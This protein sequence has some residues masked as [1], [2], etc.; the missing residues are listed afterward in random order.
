MQ[1]MSLAE[2]TTKQ[3][4]AF[5]YSGRTIAFTLM[6]TML[7]TFIATLDQTVVGTALPRIV[8]DLQGFEQIAWIT[9]IFLLTSTVTIP[10]Y[11]KLSDLF[12]RKVIFLAAITIFLIGSALCGAAQSMTHLVIFRALQGTGAGGLQPIA[13]AVVADLFSPRQ[14]GRWVG[15]TSSSYALASIV[16]PLTGGL[17]TDAVSWRWVF[18]INLPLGLIAMGVLIFVMP[19]LRTPNKR[20]IID[21]VGTLLIVLA[22][23]PLLLGFTWAGDG[24]IDWLSWQSLGLFG[25][26][27]VLLVVLVVYSAWQERLG[28]GPIVEPSMFKNVRIFSVSLLTAMLISVVLIGAVYFLPVF[29]QSV[30]GVSATNSGLTLIPFALFSIAGAVIGGQITT[31]TGRYKLQALAASVLMIVGVLLLL[32]LDVHSN[33]L[34]V[35]LALAPLGI[36][37]GSSL[38]LFIVVIQNAMPQQKIGQATAAAIF[39]R[40]I[41]QSLG[42]A[43]IGS[44]VIGSYVPA[45]YNALPSGLKQALPAQI[46]KV[47][48]NP[49]VLLSQDAMVKIGAGFEHFGAQGHAA[50]QA[51]LDAVRVGLTESIHQGFVVC[52]VLMVL[53]LVVVLFLK[54][55]PLRSKL[56]QEVQEEGES[57][58]V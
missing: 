40:Q 52:L 8:A 41:G 24:T 4:E 23:L 44:V 34:D 28:R 21:Y 17:L 9:T 16:G 57:D 37:V 29:M 48:E 49:L 51:V 5:Q 54:E 42:L 46:I 3:P 30:V 10:I 6:G 35:L 33:L 15:I 36:G 38:A 32:G 18:Y 20:V 58:V 2:Q 11:G 22:M 56:H 19:T 47:F 50:F 14:R 27:L 31:A 1:T 25:A 12:G 43:A 7:I 53:T 13:S 39:F 26:A 55:V 45:F